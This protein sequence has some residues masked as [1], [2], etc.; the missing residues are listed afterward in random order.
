MDLPFEKEIF[1]HIFVCFVLEHLVDPSMALKE[2]KK[3]LKWGGSITVIEGDHG[4]CY[5]HPESEESINAW[6]CLIMHNK[7]W[8]EIL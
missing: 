4:S 6:R 5:F 7:I 3:Y 2:L 8:A 1:D